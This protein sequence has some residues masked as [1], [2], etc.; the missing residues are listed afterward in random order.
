VVLGQSRITGA[1]ALTVTL[2]GLFLGEIQPRQW[3]A[4]AGKEFVA[5]L[6]NG[7]IVALAAAVGV[8]L[9]SDSTGLAS[10][11]AI[12]LL[13]S[14][15]VA[16]VFGAL[17]PL[18]LRSLGR[19]PARASLLVITAITDVVGIFAFLGIATAMVA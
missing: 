13:A 10:I 15:L 11:T 12:A 19:N 7:L 6:L 9:W 16:S 5:G 14:M 4:V 1:Q 8:Y 2:R 3:L 17:V 18:V